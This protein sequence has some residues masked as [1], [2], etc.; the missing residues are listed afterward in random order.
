M[1]ITR[2]APYTR[3]Q[4]LLK[5]YQFYFIFASHDQILRHYKQVVTKDNV[6]HPQ[7][8]LESIFSLIIHGSYPQY[9]DR[10]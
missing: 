7:V 4:T 3:A 2:S 8:N 10:V 6:V 9:R 1:H 5:R